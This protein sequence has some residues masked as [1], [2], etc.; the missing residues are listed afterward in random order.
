MKTQ[1]KKKKLFTLYNN[2]S[3]TQL[4]F[5]F[6]SLEVF[7]IVQDHI[8]ASSLFLLQ[9]DFYIAI[10]YIASFCLFHLQKNSGTFHEPLLIA[11]LCVFD[12]ILLIFSHIEKK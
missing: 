2:Y 5:V 1:K 3:Y 12:N 4:T 11:F 6:H 10:K 7:Y 8:D 9:N